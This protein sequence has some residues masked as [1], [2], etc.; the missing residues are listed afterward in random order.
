MTRTAAAEIHTPVEVPTADELFE[1]ARA[2]VPYLA[3]HADESNQLRRVP[4]E[5]IAKL[6]EAGLFRILQPRRWG[7]FEM[8]PE[9][10]YDVQMILGEGDMST[11][12]VYGIVGVH[13]WHLALFDDLAAKD[14][15]G[16]DQDVIVASTYMPVGK[17]AAVDG[18]YMLTGRWS[19]SSG[20]DNC[21][22]VLLGGMLPENGSD[23]PRQCSLL[24][25]KA[26]YEILDTWHVVGLKGTGSKDI[27]VENKFVPAHRVHTH[28]QGFRCDSPGN[29][30]NTGELYRLP[31]GQ[32][33]IR[34]INS[35]AVG[36][37]QGM[38]DAV[39]DY[40]VKKSGPY[41]KL[42]AN[43]TAQQTCATAAS[44]VAEIKNTMRANF[45]EME[46][47]VARAEAIPIED[48]LRYKFQAARTASRTADLAVALFRVAGGGGL[49]EA[50]PF[51]R[52]LND[53]L[54][55]RQHQFNQEPTFAANY[56]AYLLGQGTTDYFC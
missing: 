2:L 6:K 55:G 52:M 10:F 3:K 49:Q 12:W 46:A 32:V 19:F 13:N 25:P 26:D 23:D 40:A 27:V 5:T 50:Q 38:L 54:A 14:V 48:R 18:G 24:V 43:Q 31:F 22:W 1:R 37:A 11:T 36:A 39:R 4:D 16:E 33:F 42:G 34:A 51:G 45:R 44:E 17:L 15:W 41:G 53:L 56:G 7:G 30:V 9:T 28:I 29:E 20:C 21:D 47:L 8:H 35:A